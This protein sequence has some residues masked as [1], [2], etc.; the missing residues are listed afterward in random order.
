[1]KRYVYAAIVLL[2]I[3]GFAFSLNNAIPKPPIAPSPGTCCQ[4]KIVEGGDTITIY[5][6]WDDFGGELRCTCN[7]WANPKGCPLTDP[8]PESE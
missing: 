6:A 1:M 3:L 4:Y 8:C 7:P 5:G 2:F